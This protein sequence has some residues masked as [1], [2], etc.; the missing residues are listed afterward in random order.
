MQYLRNNFWE[1]VPQNTMYASVSPKM[2][3]RNIFNNSNV[4]KYYAGY[5][6][7]FVVSQLYKNT[8]LSKDSVILDPWNGSG[9]TTFVSSVLGYRSYGFDINPVMTIVAKSKLY[10]PSYN[11]VGEIKKALSVIKKIRKR[12]YCDDPLQIWFDANTANAI[13]EIELVIRYIC[14]FYNDTYMKFL[15]DFNNLSPRLAF[16]YVT[17]FELLREYTASF[18]G[19][20]PTWIKTAKNETEK[21]HKNYQQIC[22]DFYAK[23]ETLICLLDIKTDSN[24]TKIQTGDSR[25]IQLTDDSVD[26]VITSP[27]Y[28]TRID[29]AVYTRVELALVGYVANE[30]DEIRRGMIGTPT[31]K[32]TD[33]TTSERMNAWDDV[34]QQIRDHDSKAASSYYY[35]TYYQ[36]G[37][38]MERSISE[39]CRIMKVNGIVIMVIQDS[40]F[41]NIHI[42]VP[43]II[44]KSF[45]N[46]RFDVISMNSESVNNNMKY[47]NTRSR[48]YGNNQ[49]YEAILTMR[50]RG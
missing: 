31:I 50:K 6:D 37:F 40:W 2:S 16:Y 12:S 21:I 48:Q 3:N 26:C 32:D 20:N 49:N 43:M 7:N 42:N 36:Y 22:E 38:D 30:F 34:L 19:S 29:Y 41:K 18:T 24:I 35:K 4:Y 28:C 10:Y 8:E 1:G 15:L 27:P 44:C 39:I 5:S 13:R 45:E 33:E 9:T 23:L 25:K 47:I 17:L 14:D 11:D 46:H